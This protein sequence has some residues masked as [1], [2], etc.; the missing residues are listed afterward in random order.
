MLSD[1]EFRAK[2]GSSRSRYLRITYGDRNW[3]EVGEAIDRSEAL[4][5]EAYKPI[6]TQL[7]TVATELSTNDDFRTASTAAGR[8]EVTVKFLIARVGGFAP[9]TVIGDEV[10]ARAHAIVKNGRTGKPPSLEGHFCPTRCSGSP[11]PSLAGDEAITLLA[12]AAAWSIAAGGQQVALLPTGRHGV[13]PSAKQ[14]VVDGSGH[15][16]WPAGRPW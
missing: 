15:L 6:R 5:S 11:A 2:I 16:N 9:P 14:R 13:R 10:A 8:K 3:Q 4:A 12:T 7:D 1:P